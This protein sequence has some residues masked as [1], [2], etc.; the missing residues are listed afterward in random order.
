MTKNQTTTKAS[1]TPEVVHAIA[2]ATLK[3]LHERT[4]ALTAIEQT[5]SASVLDARW[6]GFTL[7]VDAHASLGTFLAGKSIAGKLSGNVNGETI[8]KAFADKSSGLY[9]ADADERKQLPSASVMSRALDIAR[10]DSA[11][12]RRRFRETGNSPT[13]QDFTVWTKLDA[14]ETLGNRATVD[15]AKTVTGKG[16]KRT[17]GKIVRKPGTATTKVAPSATTVVGFFVD[18]LKM[19]SEEL[20]TVIDESGFDLSSIPAERYRDLARCLMAS[21]VLTEQTERIVVT[22]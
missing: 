17:V 21:V 7:T 10:L 11:D 15:V 12:R 3:A 13:V 4:D 6:A 5:A 19:S 8:R 9:V 20:T 22:V 2:P 14:G 16:A 1:A 18:L